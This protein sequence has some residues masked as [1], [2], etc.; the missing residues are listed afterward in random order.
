MREYKLTPTATCCPICLSE[1]GLILW[2]V[3]ADKAAQHYVLRETG[4]ERHNALKLHIESLWQKPTCAVVRCSNCQFCFADPY[5][6][7]MTPS[8][9]LPTNTNPQITPHGDGNSNALRRH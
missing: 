6:A 8:I 5:V 2:S 3:D 1:K 4:P 9:G 7:G